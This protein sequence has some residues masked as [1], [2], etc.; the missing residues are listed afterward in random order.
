MII[1]Q[2]IYD[3]QKEATI[4]RTEKK[5]NQRE[6]EER[7]QNLQNEL[8]SLRNQNQQFRQYVQEQKEFQESIK[9]IKEEI[10]SSDQ[11]KSN[12]QEHYIQRLAKQLESFK[13][14]HEYLQNELALQKH[15]KV[16]IK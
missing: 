3:L 12:E 4:L 5:K 10:S 1:D 8:T 6:K 7:V 13:K 15:E 2:L 9:K 14:H 16:D 11:S